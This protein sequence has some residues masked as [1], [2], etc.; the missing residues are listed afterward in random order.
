MFTRRKRTQGD[1]AEELQSHLALEADRMREAGISEEEAMAA[2][3]RNLGNMTQAQERFYEAHRWLWLDDLIQDWR[4]GL[5]QLRR[6]PG[7]TAVAVITLALGIGATTAMFSVVNGVLLKPLPY[8]N[9]DRVM[10]L[11]NTTRKYSVSSVSYP[12]FLDWQRMNR[13]FTDLAA[14][15]WD[16]FNLSAPSGAEVVSALMVSANFFK[17]VGIPPMLGRGFSAVDDH[18]GAAPTVV[19]SYNFWQKHFGGQSSIIGKPVTMD[20][21]SYSVIGILP[22]N[23]WFFGQQFRTDVFVPIGIYDRVWRHQRL[24]HPGLFVVGRL[25]PAVTQGQAQADMATVADRLAQQ[26][27]KDD[28]GFGIKMSPVLAWSVKNSRGTLWLL[29]GAVCF[30]LLIACVNV[31]NLLLSRATSRRREIAIRVALGAGVRRVV[32]QLVTESVLLGLLAGGVGVLLAWAGTR[33]L[34]AEIPGDLPRSQNVDLDLRV[35]LFVVGISVITGIIFGLAPALRS[36]KPDLDDA[37]KEGSR[38][39]TGGQHRLQNGLVMAEIGLA[40]VL[41][42]GAGL[43]LKSIW[44]LD[45]VNIGFNPHH[46]LSFAVS[47]PPVRY[48]DANNNRTFYRDLLAKLRALPGVRT[49]GATDLMPLS[50]G[51]NEWPFY[52]EGRPKPQMQNMPQTM[53]YITTPGY[54]GAMGISLLRGRFF[55]NQDNLSS[56][57]VVVIDD[58]FARTM[59]PNQNPIGQHIIFPLPGFDAP[60]EI[61]GVAHHIK[62][63][64]PAGKKGWQVQNDLYMPMAQLPDLFYRSGG[65]VNLTLVVRTS[66]DPR[67]MTAAVTKTVH[68][69]DNGVAVNAVQT[70]TAM[71]RSSLVA[72]RF[73][74]ILMAIFAALALVLAAIGIYG[75]ISYSVSQRTHEIG[76]RVALGAQKR[77]VLRHVLGQ[78]MLLAVI[79]LGMGI[80]AALGMTRFMASLLYGVKPTDPLTF[81]LVSLILIGVA[82]LACYIPARRAT[83]VD[84]IVALRYE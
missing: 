4:Y 6:N 17:V 80:I 67:A 58:V 9:P 1:F 44:Y 73:T 19:L 52:L 70:I 48:Q 41:L 75:V 77:D 63:F 14:C 84:P 79:G 28:A 62:H 5:R 76:I 2:A 64:G 21:K 12:D 15:R 33:L 32:R 39:S 74:M 36:A 37:L 27:P 10:F 51:D 35:L 53:F 18:L 57:L 56:Q 81:L 38:G 54:L 68:S 7:F 8:P 24:Y 29:L 13:S 16:G 78:G 45:S 60:R 49:A 50:G 23:F 34:L 65:V 55:T 11:Y 26:Y 46:A 30:V 42:A 72:Q 40:L 69:I 43:T 71:E 3:R 31:A 22:K 83:K 66:V 20:G 25:K 59:F 82:L 61:V 47:L